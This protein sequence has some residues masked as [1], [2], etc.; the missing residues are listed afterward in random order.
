MILGLKYIISKA[1]KKAR[2][3][4]IRCSVIDPTSKIESGS[5]FIDSSIGRNSFC[6]YDCEVYRARIGAFVSIAN[7]VTLGGA[8]HPMEWVGM[9]PV[10]YAGRDSVRTKY[11]EHALPESPEI[12][13]G[14]D[15][16]IGHSAIVLSGVKI[17][18]GAVV[19]AGSVVT[20]DVPAYAVVAGNPARI[21]RYRF[22]EET[23]R[24]LEEIQW[25]NFDEDRLKS[26]GVLAQDVQRF[27][28]E[29]RKLQIPNNKVIE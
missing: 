27:V 20:K 11:A 2:L 16:W 18:N 15:V 29:S 19:G 3:A 26:L 9:S 25:W 14:N 10:F 21:L 4:S 8:R 5:A 7:R 17:G 23:I 12:V 1:L 13:V 22:D 24:E 28:E 6:G